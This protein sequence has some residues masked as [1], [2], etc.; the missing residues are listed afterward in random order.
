MHELLTRLAAAWAATGAAEATAAALGLVYV[1]LAIR[2]HPACWLAALVSTALYTWVFYRAGLVLQAGLQAYYVAVAVYGWWAWR[3][4]PGTPAPVVRRASWRLQGGG[5]VA[6][7]AASALALAALGPTARTPAG[8][9]DA[10]TTWAS[11]FATWLVARK[12]LENWAWWF[13][14]DAL[15]AVLCWRQGLQATA[16]LYGAFLVLVVIG[17]RAWARDLAAAPG[18]VSA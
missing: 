1:L 17:W 5:L 10:V 8:L 4:R 3:G 12:Y 2:Q 9:L 6:V 15:I 14:I 18:G 11:V 7:A 13:V 16:V